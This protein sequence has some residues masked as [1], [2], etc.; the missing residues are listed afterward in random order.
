[1]HISN[2][3]QVTDCDPGPNT[4]ISVQ[5]TEHKATVPP[6]FDWITEP[7]QYFHLFFDTELLKL[8]LQETTLNGN[9]KKMQSIPS[10]KRA[11]ITDWWL[12]TT[13]DIKA[14]LGIVINMGLHPC[15]ILLFLSGMGEQNA[16]LFLCVPKG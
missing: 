11:S 2:W 4:P 8:I 9:R 14:L 5:N 6:S 7:D 12:S 3:L 1:M 13:T 15:L 10:T 16:L